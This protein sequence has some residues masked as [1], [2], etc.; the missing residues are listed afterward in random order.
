MREREAIPY[1]I[2]HQILNLQKYCRDVLFLFKNSE[3]LLNQTMTAQESAVF[4]A[5]AKL[6]TMDHSLVKLDTLTAVKDSSKPRKGL[7]ISTGYIN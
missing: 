6:L 5:K 4:L 7:L 3:S 1:S 2:L